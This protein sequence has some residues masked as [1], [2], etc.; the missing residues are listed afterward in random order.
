MRRGKL[1]IESEGKE[2]NNHKVNVSWETITRD[3][4][5]TG[6]RIHKLIWV[7]KVKRD[8]TA[9]GQV[10]LSRFRIHIEDILYGKLATARFANIGIYTRGSAK[11]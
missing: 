2:L 10:R 8:G 4:L 7:Y 6:R 1:W 11:G 5:P 3:E 9:K